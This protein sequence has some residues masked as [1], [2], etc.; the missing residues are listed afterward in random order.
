[1]RSGSSRCSSRGKRDL[2]R[3]R[4]HEPRPVGAHLCGAGEGLPGKADLARRAV[5]PA[6]GGGVRAEERGDGGLY[7]V[8]RER[9]PQGGER[10]LRGRKAHVLGLRRGALRPPAR[11]AL[12][13]GALRAHPRRADRR[14][15]VFVRRGAGAARGGR[16]EALFRHAGKADRFLRRALKGAGDRGRARDAGHG[17]ARRPAGGAAGARKARGLRRPLPRG[18][19]RAHPEAERRRAAGARRR[20]DGGHRQGALDRGARGDGAGTAAHGGRENAGDAAACGEKPGKNRS[21]RR[22]TARFYI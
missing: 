6:Y 16:C 19:V 11:A 12:R 5:R 18:A 15:R 3:P 21:E 1:M 8:D 14:L 4:A 10:R 2:A 9:H 17:R 20:A 22:T 13:R 7:R